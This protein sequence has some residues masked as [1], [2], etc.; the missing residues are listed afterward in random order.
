MY[1]LTICTYICT[2][3]LL[4]RSQVNIVDTDSRELISGWVL[5]THAQAPVVMRSVHVFMV[6]FVT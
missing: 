4:R 3:I 1:V 5:A 2:H 6:E